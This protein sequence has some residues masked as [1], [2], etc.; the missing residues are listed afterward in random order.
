M[1]ETAEY[2]Y[3]ERDPP[4][5]PKQWESWIQSM[6]FES[7]EEDEKRIDNEGENESNK[8]RRKRGNGTREQSKWTAKLIT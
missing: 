8:L 3:Y 2:E 7:Q 4:P 6:C 5:P 1:L